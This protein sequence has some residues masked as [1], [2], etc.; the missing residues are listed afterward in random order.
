MGSNCTTDD[1]T[2]SGV[3]AMSPIAA[4]LM[5]YLAHL[6]CPLQSLLL[7]MYGAYGKT[8]ENDKQ[9]TKDLMRRPLKSNQHGVHETD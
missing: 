5:V 7:V 9:L 3:V 1:W 4:A 6:H 2:D 8:S